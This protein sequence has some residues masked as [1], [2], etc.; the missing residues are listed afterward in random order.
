MVAHVVV[1]AHQGN[2]D[3]MLFVAIP[4]VLF[5]LL[6]RLANRRADRQAATPPEA[7]APPV[8]PP[9]VPLP[10]QDDATPSSSGPDPTGRSGPDQR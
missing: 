1:L 5:V 10:T 2:W 3:E 8:E 7:P 9:G 4:I 6:L